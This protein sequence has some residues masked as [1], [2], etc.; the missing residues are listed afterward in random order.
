MSMDAIVFNKPTD[1]FVQTIRPTG[2]GS[3]WYGTCEVC[4]THASSIEQLQRHRVWQKQTGEMYLSSV[5]AG[6]Y[7][8]AG[9][10]IKA[11]GDALADSQ[12]VR[13]DRLKTVSPEQFQQLTKATGQ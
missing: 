9:C 6:A 12:F 8:H 2:R 7:G 1:L 13:V 4:K 3:D 10:L 5:G 11:F